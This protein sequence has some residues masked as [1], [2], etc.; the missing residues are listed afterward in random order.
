MRKLEI[1]AEAKNGVAEIRITGR[2]DRWWNGAEEFRSQV[3]ALVASGVKDVELYLNSEGGDVFEAAEIVN[4]IRKFPG[5]VSGRGGSIV[6]SAATYIALHCDSFTLAANSQYMI[7]KPHGV[8]QGNEDGVEAQLRLLRNITTDY[9]RAYA[10]KTGKPEAEI[11]GLIKN[12]YWLTA[13]DAKE[14]GF[15][16]AVEGEATVTHTDAAV[17]L[18]CGSPLGSP[19]ISKPKP[20]SV[21]MQFDPTSLGLPAEASPQQVEAK[22]TELKA[23]AAKADQLEAAAKAKA[24]QDKKDRVQALITAAVQ[25]KKVMEGWRGF[26]AKMGESDPDGLEAYLDDIQPVQAVS[27][28]LGGQ[29]SGN[30]NHPALQAGKDYGWHL[31]HKPEALEQ[32]REEDPDGFGAYVDTYYGK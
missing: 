29:P 15:V 24:E 19:S 1:I 11:R 21:K 8:V 25:T 30:A 10:Q 3:D 2:I 20:Q 17:I 27:G 12:D 23:K 4:I 22:L 6:A 7:H 18:A 5:K 31:E 14:Q 28:Q 26:L 13:K 9:V 16:D 32:F